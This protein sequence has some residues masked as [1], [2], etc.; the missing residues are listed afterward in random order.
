MMR[1]IV[2]KINGTNIPF[3]KELNWVDMIAWEIHGSATKGE[4]TT[5]T[6]FDVFRL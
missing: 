1:S 6:Y 3:M 5:I 4:M 2:K